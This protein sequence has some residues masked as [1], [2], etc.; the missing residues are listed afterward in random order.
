MASSN[1]KSTTYPH[2]KIRSLSTR[3][4]PRI[5]SI[6]LDQDGNSFVLNVGMLLGLLVSDFH[7]AVS[8]YTLVPGGCTGG[9]FTARAHA[10]VQ[11]LP[12]PSSV[13]W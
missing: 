2:A 8:I 3:L 7:A 9:V 13:L 11:L 4:S 1:K 10:P 6:A 12:S 5:V